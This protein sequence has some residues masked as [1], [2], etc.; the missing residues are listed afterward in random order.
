MDTKKCPFC[1]EEIR[2]EAVKCRFCGEWLKSTKREGLAETDMEAL[3]V[4]DGL[5]QKELDDTWFS[6]T[7]LFWLFISIAIGIFVH[8]IAGIAIF[9]ICLFWRANKWLPKK[10][11]KS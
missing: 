9:V 3:N 6:M 4:S 11:K 10:R 8:P 7:I 5:K 1:K 2:L